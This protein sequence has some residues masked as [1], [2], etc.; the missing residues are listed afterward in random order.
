MLLSASSF[1]NESSAALSAELNVPLPASR[2]YY[3]EIPAKL[4]LGTTG[5]VMLSAKPDLKSQAAG[6]LDDAWNR[7][8]GLLPAGT[9][10][11]IWHEPD[12]LI[13]SGK[14][15][16]ALWVKAFDQWVAHA[17]GYP[18]II[19]MLNL[20]NGPWSFAVEDAKRYLTPNIPDVFGLDVYQDVPR[21]WRTPETLC[22]PP[23]EWAL[24]HGFADLAVPEFGAVADARR[25]QFVHDMVSWLDRWD[26]V[27]LANYWTDKGSVFDVR[28]D[29]AS[30]DALRSEILRH[31]RG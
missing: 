17:K 29:K 5:A 3:R 6:V 21:N 11:T 22:G 31:Q 4:S 28:A 18:G 27:Q 23:F 19:T 2:V 10:V 8:Y 15:D 12:S 7:L 26:T 20:T 25:P 24:T 30:R 1:A 9:V 14:L 13:R 16:Y